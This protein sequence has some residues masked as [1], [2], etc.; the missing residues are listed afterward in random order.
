MSTPLTKF[1]EINILI[2]PNYIN[3]LW[4]LRIVFNLDCIDDLLEVDIPPTITKATSKEDKAIHK[5]DNLLVKSYMLAVI[6][7]EL[8]RTYE[9]ITSAWVTRMHMAEGGDISEHVFK[10]ISLFKR[11]KSLDFVMDANL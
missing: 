10:M 6:I 5:A 7:N 2:R 11:L 3:C 4:N 8:R 1:I 9:N